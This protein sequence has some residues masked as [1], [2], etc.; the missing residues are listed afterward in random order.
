MLYF[1]RID[2]IED[3]SDLRRGIPAAHRVYSLGRTINSA[4]YVY[5]LALNKLIKDCPKDKV[6]EASEIFVEVLLQLHLGQG[7]EL[8][9]RDN[10]ICPTEKQYL[11]M[12]R[13]KT[14]GLYCLGVRIMQALSEKVYNFCPII[15]RLSE[16]AQIRND[17]INL[18]DDTVNM[19]LNTTIL[20]LMSSF[21]M[22]H[23]VINLYE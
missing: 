16:W 6:S 1:N 13:R 18:T 15:E 8:Y 7:M 14:G 5:F 10:F 4:N 19:I 3:N 22:T 2:D 20:K 21:L 23:H 9:W 17:Y 11:N 12:V